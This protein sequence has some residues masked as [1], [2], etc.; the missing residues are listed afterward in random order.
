MSNITIVDT[1][2][3][4]IVLFLRGAVVIYSYQSRHTE[5]TAMVMIE[6][7]VNVG[8]IQFETVL[9]LSGSSCQ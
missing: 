4:T 6:S 7:L 5:K 9:S 1:I 2:V 3:A 8:V